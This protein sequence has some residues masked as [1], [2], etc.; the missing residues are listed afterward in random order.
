MARA[1]VPVVPGYGG[2]R[3]EPD[4]LKQKAYEIGYP[5]L[6][7]AV[8]GGGGRGMRRVDRA[9]DFEAGARRRA[10]ARRCAAFGDDRVLIERYVDTPRHIEVQ[11]FAD[12]ARQRRASLRARLL[13]AAP[14]PEGDRGGA[15]A[16]PAGRDA[17][18]AWARRRSRPRRPSAIAAPARSSSSPTRRSGLTP[19]RLL[20][21]GDEHAAAGRASGDRGG[22]RARPGRMAAAGRGRRAAA[23]PPGRDRAARP[24][25]SRRASTPRIRRPASG[26]RPAGSGRRRFPSGAGHPRRCRRRSRD[27]SS[28]RYYDS[29][30]AKVIAHGADRA[31]GAGAARRG[32]RPRP[33]S[34]GRRPISPS[35]PPSSRHPDSAPAASIPASSTASSTR[36]SARRSTRRLRPAPSRNGSRAKRGA[37]PARRAG[38]WART[39]AFELGGLE[40][41]SELDVEVDGEPTVAELAWSAGGPTVVVDR[42]RR[43]DRPRGRRRSSGATA[44][45]SCCTAA[46]QLRVALPRSAGA[47]SR[48]G[49]AASGEV[50]APMH[51]RVVAVAVAPGDACRE[52]RARSSRWRP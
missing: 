20:L 5:V 29:M 37:S 4:F 1:G 28:A 11:V 34:P 13:G 31:R 16:G 42:R 51:G 35:C 26:R 43:R 45:P 22:D 19:R 52:G 23:A 7:K 8:A 3:Q 21:H 6:I 41:R 18:S 44:R 24:C 50:A 30:L 38:P 15:G 36:S 27:R 12:S 33:A 48:G 2:E 32:A 46:R 10:S 17:R 9:L 47:R 14:P 25:R 49:E 39:D 40:R